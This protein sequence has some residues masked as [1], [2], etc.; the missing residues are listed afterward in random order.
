MQV[1]RNIAQYH[2]TAKLGAGG[3]GE[4]WLATDTR[5]RREVALKFL[6][7]AVSRDHDR[8]ARFEREAR[9]LASLNHPK[10]GAIYG[11]DLHD[12]DTP[13]L[14]LELIPGETLAE[15]LD[16]GPLQIGIA[17]PIAAQIAEALDAA[18]AKGIVHRDLK[19]ANIK[20][21]PEGTVKVLDFGLGKFGEDVAGPMDISQSPTR[22]IE[23]TR[24]GLIMGTAA[25]MSPE[26]ARGKLADHR[27][28]IWAFG[29]VLYEM[30]T[31]RR[32]FPGDTVSDILAGVLRGEPE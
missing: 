11:L 30:L 28:D 27:S 8:L 20:I 23:A 15:R 9:L 7:E 5:L 1:G 3:M 18:H 31:A 6:P 32:A 29:C 26:Q 12:G 14:V 22:T 19:P 24:A 25:Y 4:V 21:T 13:F 17:L 10:V 16:R 2:I